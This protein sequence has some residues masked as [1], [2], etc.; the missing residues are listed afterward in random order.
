MGVPDWLGSGELN[1]L[2]GLTD[3]GIGTVNSA[4]NSGPS[5]QVLAIAGIDLALPMPDWSY[6]LITK[7]DPI[8]HQWSKWLGGNGV[9]ALAFMFPAS[10]QISQ[11]RL[12]V[13][14]AEVAGRSAQTSID[15]LIFQLRNGNLNP[16]IG[17]RPIGAGISEARAADGARVYFRQLADGTIEILGKSIKS[18]QSKV[19][20][21][22]LRLFGGS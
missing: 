15:R 17:T 22:I 8:L 2:N 21:E 6:G 18:N 3:I 11:S 19:I 4:L 13:R 9:F 14:E 20:S 16:G 7:E 10:S 1:I 5:G 12:L